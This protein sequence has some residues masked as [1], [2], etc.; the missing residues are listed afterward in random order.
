MLLRIEMNIWVYDV[1]ILRLRLGVEALLIVP[2]IPLYITDG[3]HT[4]AWMSKACIIDS[5]EVKFE[6]IWK[7]FTSRDVKCS[8]SMF[9]ERPSEYVM[10]KFRGKKR[11]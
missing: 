10:E 8:F 9:G 4:H 3:L 1:V 5:K 7:K 2:L 6:I 11:G